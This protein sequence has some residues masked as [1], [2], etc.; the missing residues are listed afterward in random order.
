MK[1][2]TWLLCIQRWTLPQ[3]DHLETGAVPSPAPLPPQDLSGHTVAWQ[4]VPL[5]LSSS[6]VTPD[7]CS[8]SC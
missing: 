3:L 6:F 7:A 2:H 8:C 5:P 1:Y 4:R